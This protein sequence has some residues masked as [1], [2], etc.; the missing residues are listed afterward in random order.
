MTPIKDSLT[1]NDNAFEFI[2]IGSV[3]AFIIGMGLQIYVV[4]AKSAVFSLIDFGIGVGSLLTGTG[5]GYGAKKFGDREQSGTTTTV[6]ET[7]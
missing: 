2:L 1:G 4:L 6:T 3:L 7:K 5:L